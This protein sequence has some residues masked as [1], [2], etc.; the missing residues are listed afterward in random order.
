MHAFEQL[1]ILILTNVNV[2]FIRDEILVYQIKSYRL[3][4]INGI[5]I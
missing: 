1:V 4:Y 5:L 3:S 2:E